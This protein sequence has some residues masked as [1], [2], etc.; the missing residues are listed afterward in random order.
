[1]CN[2]VSGHIL[3]PNSGAASGIGYAVARQL[4]LDGIHHLV[5]VDRADESL[6]RA[7][8]S[9]GKVKEGPDVV[10]IAVTA[11]C[12]DETD[13]NSAVQTAVDQF[14][15]LDICFNAA[16]ISGNGG[17][18]ADTDVSELDR[19]LGVNLRGLWLC[20]RAQIRQMMKQELR[21]VAYAVFLPSHLDNLAHHHRTGLP[22]KTRGSIVNVGSL[23]SHAAISNL[24]PYIMSK[25]GVLGLTKS[26]AFDYGKEG[27]RVNCIC[28]GWISTNM[29]QVFHAGGEAAAVSPFLFDTVI[30]VG[31]IW[32]CC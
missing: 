2:I 31:V 26:D 21:D 14:G 27:I 20:E 12:S 25:H 1:M 28:P 16:G 32:T 3:I 15:R 22:L 4:I 8:E 30:H 9:L 13:V 23:T 18:I 10:I 24:S 6:R 29:T 11:D 7:I 5:I 19:I 17:A